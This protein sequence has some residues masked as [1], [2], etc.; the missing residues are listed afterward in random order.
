MKAI[1]IVSFIIVLAWS[2]V[3]ACADPIQWQISEGGNGH[4]YE[5]VV[6]ISGVTWMQARDFAISRGGYLATIT[7]LEENQFVY[8][9]VS[10]DDAYWC[11]Y[12]GWT[13]GPWLGGYK[14]DDIWCWVT[15]ETWSYTNWASGM[16]DNQ[17][18]IEDSLAF[19]GIRDTSRTD[20]WNDAYG[21]SS[22]AFCS[23]VIEFNSIPEPASILT[24]ICGLGGIALK[25]RK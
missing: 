7:S 24:I 13:N 3:V 10:N 4:Y 9:F 8:G 21:E 6:D 18:G 19:G 15:D 14:N 2:N 25:R 1:A 16:P 17:S 12:D 11:I 5:A 23:Y 20:L 22:Y